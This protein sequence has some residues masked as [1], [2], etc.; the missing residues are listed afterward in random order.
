MIDY[1]KFF[2]NSTYPRLETF[3]KRIGP[4]HDAYETKVE[5]SE[6]KFQTLTTEWKNHSKFKRYF[7]HVD[8]FYKIL[9]EEI[10]RE[11]DRE[12]IR[13]MMNREKSKGEN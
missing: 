9:S 13:E 4:G 10:G 7:E 11:I 8:E 6:G 3:V 2:D 1:E 12:I 5:I